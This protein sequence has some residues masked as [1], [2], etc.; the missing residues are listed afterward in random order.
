MTLPT[1]T[2]LHLAVVGCALVVAAVRPSHPSVAPDGPAAPTAAPATVPAATLL[3]AEHRSSRPRPAT[4]RARGPA[5]RRA[6]RPEPRRHLS[7][8]ARRAHRAHRAQAAGPTSWPAL[9]AAIAS[10][11]TYRDNTVRWT[12]S[13]RYPYWGTA[14][15][16]RRVIYVSPGVPSSYVYDVA[17]HE[18]SHELS[19]LDY[20][21]DVARATAAMDAYF[22]GTG[23][24]GAER[25]ADCMAILQGATWT[26]YTSCPSRAWRDGAALLVRGE[27]L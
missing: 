18:W 5:T 8:R 3:S 24:V 7:G 25:A 19:V 10:I 13:R 20:D 6:P 9:N 26:H 12:V 4:R 21:G 27:K 15:W 2:A 16:Y 11:P 22:G 23:L 1:R 17:V 14:D